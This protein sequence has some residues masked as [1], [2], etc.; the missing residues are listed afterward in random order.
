MFFGLT[1]RLIFVVVYICN[2]TTDIAVWR[3]KAK[4][5]YVPL[6]KEARTISL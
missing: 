2:V 5:L 3:V 6:N 4:W 1:L